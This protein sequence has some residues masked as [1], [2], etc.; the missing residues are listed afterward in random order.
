MASLGN[1]RTPYP[2]KRQVSRLKLQGREAE[3]QANGSLVNPLEAYNGDYW[4]FEKIGEFLPVDYVPPATIPSP[5][6]A[7]R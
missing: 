6:P 1:T 3:I 5:T 7:H 4:G 2:A